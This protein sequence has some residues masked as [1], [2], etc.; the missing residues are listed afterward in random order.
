MTEVLHDAACLCKAACGLNGLHSWELSAYDP[1]RHFHHPLLCFML[2][3]FVN[4]QYR[5]AIHHVIVG[6]M[7]QSIKSPQN[8]G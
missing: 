2:L 3:C 8:C 6:S 7:V 1:H 5:D 4:L